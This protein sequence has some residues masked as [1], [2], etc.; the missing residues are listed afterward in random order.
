MDAPADYLHGF[1]VDQ[2]FVF[3]S[4]WNGLDWERRPDAPR[5]EYWTS[6]FGHDYSYGHGRGRRTYSPRPTHPAIE[7]VSNALEARFGWR[8]EGMFANGYESERD[9]LGWHAD[10]DPTID[11]TR[12]IAVV[13]VGAGRAIQFKAIGGEGPAEEL[14]LEPGSLLLMRAGMQSTHMHRIPKASFRAAP[15]ISL[16]FRGLVQAT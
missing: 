4:L 5:R 8:Y 11:H 6:S 13:T 1:V 2:A 15:R 9:G 3:D 12:P 14:F 16:T 10:D 7:A